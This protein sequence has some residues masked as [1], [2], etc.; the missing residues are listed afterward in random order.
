[1]VLRMVAT[2][3]YIFGFRSQINEMASSR[4]PKAPKVLYLEWYKGG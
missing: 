1:M 4:G 2:N 3:G